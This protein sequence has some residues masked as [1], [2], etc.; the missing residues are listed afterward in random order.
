MKRARDNSVPKEAKYG[1][2]HL[3]YISDKERSVYSDVELKKIATARCA[4]VS[5]K[6][7]DEGNSNVEKDLE[8]FDKL[9]NSEPVHSSPSEHVATV[10][11]SLESSGNIIGFMQFRKEISNETVWG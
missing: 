1:Y 7:F 10:L 5:Y 2:L 9:C 8:L 6:P 11:N 3:P 4:R